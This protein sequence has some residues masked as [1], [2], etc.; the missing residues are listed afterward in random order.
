MTPQKQSAIIALSKTGVSICETAA[1]GYGSKSAIGSIV[2]R[3][4]IS[5][6]TSPAMR[7][8]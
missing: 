3:F 1:E 7:T 8:V 4:N 6:S 5:L 2:K